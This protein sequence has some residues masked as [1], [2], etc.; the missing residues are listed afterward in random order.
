ML[1]SSDKTLVG[2]TIGAVIT[3]VLRFACHV[4]SGVFAFGAYAVDEGQGLWAYSLAY[5]SFVFVDIALVIVAGILVFSSKA[6]QKTIKD[7]VEVEK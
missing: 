5:N 6:F 2:F 7:K 3:G 1:C 4:L